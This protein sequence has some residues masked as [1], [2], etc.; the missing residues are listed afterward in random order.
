MPR[1]LKDRKLLEAELTLVRHEIA[2][3]VDRLARGGVGQV[4]VLEGSAQALEWVLA[5]KAS[6]GP[7]SGTVLDPTNRRDLW[8]EA[9][10][11]E[12]VMNNPYVGVGRS[13]DEYERQARGLRAKGVHDTLEWATGG[14]E[15]TAR[16]VEDDEIPEQLADLLAEAGR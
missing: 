4:V 1:G 8:A 12:D 10:R 16:G 11:A 9:S 2:N 13:I 15:W 6:P 5:G 14:V 7:I 3:P